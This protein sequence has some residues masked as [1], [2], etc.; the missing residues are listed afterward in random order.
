MTCVFIF[1]GTPILKVDMKRMGCVF[2]I[3][4]VITIAM[5]AVLIVIITIVLQRKWETIR[6]FMFM[7]F[8][9]LAN[10]DGPENLEN[11]DFDAYVT[12]R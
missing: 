10:N 5:A 11:I 9:I 6:F 1:T 4:A 12:Y 7:H 2:P 3:W 8:D